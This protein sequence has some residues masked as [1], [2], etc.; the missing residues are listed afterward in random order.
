MS[1]YTKLF[2]SILAST[3]WEADM[4][5]RIVWITL[6]AMK[7][8]HGVVEASIPGLATFAR[9]TIPQARAALE[10]LKAADPDSRTQEEEGRRIR[11]I[12]G[13]W[14]VIN[15]DK[16]RRLL[17]V[18]ERREYLRVKQA[19]YRAKQKSTPVNTVS[20]KS[21]MLTHTEEEAEADT[22]ADQ[23]SVVPVDRK[24][25]TKAAPSALTV[26]FDAFWSAYP[27]KAGKAA[28]LKSWTRIKPANGQC[29][30]ILTAI[31][32]QSLTEQWQRDGG[33]FIPNPA[34]WLN[35]GRWDDE[36]IALGPD[37]SATIDARQVD[38]WEECKA[39]H[40]GDCNGD[41]MRHHLRVQMDRIKAG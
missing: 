29:E 20:D 19:E 38:W 6:L 13:G 26:A 12:E 2:N 1:G 40:A 24:P 16:Y 5:T 32:Q 30:R 27:K 37:V 21:T 18:E 36:P 33:R 7:D 8:Q 41:R 17:S 23:P 15:H 11:D 25:R 39:L 4:P 34:T 35:Q 10:N 28:A 31:H 22:E 14:Y 3:I 9:V